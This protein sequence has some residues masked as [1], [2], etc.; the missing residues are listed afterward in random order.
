MKK[1]RR[2][3][4]LLGRFLLWL[5]F[6]ATLA[7]SA[8]AADRAPLLAS[9]ATESFN[10]IDTAV[11]ALAASGDEKAQIVLSA[12]ADRRLFYN[13]ADKHIF[14]KDENGKNFDALTDAELPAVPASLKP[15]RIN[16][17]V[18]ATID[19]ALGSLTLTA[20]DP[21]RR[22][23]AAETVFK[24]RNV[25]SLGAIETA[26]AKETE[27]SVRRA[28]EEARAAILI[29]KVDI[30]QEARLDAIK[31]IRDRGDQDALA[32]LRSIGVEVPASI[33]SAAETAAA[34]IENRLALWA[35]VQNGWY[36]LSL[37]SV[38]LLAA[39]GLAVTFGVMGVINMAHGEMV[40]LGAYASFTI[41]EIMRARGSH[42]LGAALACAVPAA[43]LVSGMVGVIIERCVIRFLYGR[44]LETLLATFGISLILQQAVR[45]AFGP[46]N[47]EVDTP[48][49]MS[50]A[51][52]L[53]GMQITLN[54]LA[55][56]VF[57]V[58]VFLALQLVL[59]FTSFGLRTRAVTQN[60]RMASSMGIR[61][62]AIDALT[63]GLGSGIA[64]LA[65]VA[66]SQI[67]NVSPNLGQGYIIDCFLVVVFG[68]VGNLW[69]TLIGAVSI[70]MANKFL[71]PFA[72]A[73]LGK[74]ALLVFIILFI[75]KR[76]RGLFALKGRAVET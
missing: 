50:G 61:T 2:G 32:L 75:Q 30:G 48:A 14:R 62:N 33:R 41:Q 15:V 51:F 12:L 1:M 52:E 58:A 44:P 3:L 46:T 56:M 36:G 23:E 4:R 24:S 76:P 43:F 20:P 35:I 7:S 39:I 55:I 16:N 53:A 70:G 9:F 60:R 73:V 11:V 26:L 25:A 40:M 74:I 66:L 8:R 38:L 18:R 10:E 19:A 34:A 59:R 5:A 68:G 13:P 29:G 45:T 37:G 54:R 71:E 22:R 27:P 49:F 31:V 28:L 67:D 42:N 64:G 65:G 47:R 6:I 63:F 57:A 72:G 69:G 21:A 17:R